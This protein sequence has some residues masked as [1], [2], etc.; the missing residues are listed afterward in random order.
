VDSTRAFEADA[1]LQ[2]LAQDIQ[3]RLQALGA[4]VA[5]LKMT[6]DPH[7][8]FGDLA[9]INL[10]RNDFVPELSQKLPEPVAGGEL[11]STSGRGRAGRPP[12]PCGGFG[13]RSR[14]CA[15]RGRGDMA[16]SGI[17]QAWQ[18]ST[19][20]SCDRGGPAMI[21]AWFIGEFWGTFH[22]E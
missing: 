16:E 22:S 15:V 1:L 10:V 6:F 12:P 20:P 21:P 13:G 3:T 8:T 17:I 11:T 4:E 18:T 9:V 5:H 19:D 7:S 14:L 2:C